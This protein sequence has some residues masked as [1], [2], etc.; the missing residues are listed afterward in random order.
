MEEGFQENLEHNEYSVQFWRKKFEEL[1]PQLQKNW[2]GQLVAFDPS[3]DSLKG[4]NEMRSVSH[5]KGSLVVTQ[6]VV[7]QL[8]KML[9]KKPGRRRINR[10]PLERLNLR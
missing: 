7:S 9:S 8:E 2:H 3:F 6:K 1:K 4:A 5:K 10:T